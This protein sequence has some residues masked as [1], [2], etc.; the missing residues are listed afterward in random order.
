MRNELPIAEIPVTVQIFPTKHLCHFQEQD[1]LQSP[2]IRKTAGYKRS[3]KLL[4]SQTGTPWATK[5]LSNNTDPKLCYINPVKIPII[6]K[7]FHNTA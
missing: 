6:M 2:V 1:T 5:S 3:L 7:K 4:F